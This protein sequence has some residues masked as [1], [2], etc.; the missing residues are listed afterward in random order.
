MVRLT[1]Y[2]DMTVVVNSG[3]KAITQQQQQFIEQKNS[4]EML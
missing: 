1:D 3:L 4:S 2:L